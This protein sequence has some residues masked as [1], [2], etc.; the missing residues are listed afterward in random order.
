MTS[1]DTRALE[2]AMSEHKEAEAFAFYANAER[3]QE[4]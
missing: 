1:E 2:E 3:I 4:N